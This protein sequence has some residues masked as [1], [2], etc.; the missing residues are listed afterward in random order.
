MQHTHPLIIDEKKILNRP[1]IAHEIQI[2]LQSG[3]TM[4]LITNC[5]NRKFGLSIDYATIVR[6][7]DRKRKEVHE[8]I[9]FNQSEVLQLLQMLEKMKR[10]DPA[11]KFSYVFDTTF[12]E[13]DGL[14]ASDPKIVTLFIQTPMM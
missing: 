4:P 5:I 2:Y 8:Y 3:L 11:M 12:N 14:D 13:R 6:Y 7:T 1:E 9:D 10:E